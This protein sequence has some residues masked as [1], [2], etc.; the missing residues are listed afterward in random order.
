MLIKPQLEKRPLNQTLNHS[1]S[2]A[3]CSIVLNFYV[4]T[5]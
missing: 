5:T 3:S 2:I 4:R 1:D